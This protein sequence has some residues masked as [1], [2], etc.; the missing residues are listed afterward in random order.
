MI[1]AK[2]WLRFWTKVSLGD[3]CWEWMGTKSRGYGQF[4]QNGAKTPAH[5]IAWIFEYGSIPK[6]KWVLH[7]CDNKP[8]VRHLFLG[9]PSDNTHDMIS[10]GR[11]KWPGAPLKTHCKHG[12]PMV[13]GNILQHK[14]RRYCAQ[15]Q[16]K[17]GREFQQRKRDEA[18]AV[19]I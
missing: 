8:C 5:R 11:Q 9:T 16:R 6:K 15:C 7:E 14:K 13:S 18:K 4:S 17:A 1:D 10:K 2:L 19:R 3:G 12:H